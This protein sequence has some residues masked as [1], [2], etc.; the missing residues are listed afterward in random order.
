[1]EHL[2]ARTPAVS[3]ATAE[4]TAVT[5]HISTMQLLLDELGRLQDQVLA[6]LD[7][8]TQTRAVLSAFSRTR[9]HF[10]EIN[11]SFVPESSS[12]IVTRNMPPG[13]TGAPS[14]PLTWVTPPPSAPFS[15][16]CLRPSVGTKVYVFTTI[17][18]R[19]EALHTT[20]PAHPIFGPCEVGHVRAPF[21]L[22]GGRGAKTSWW[23]RCNSL[24]DSVAKKMGPSIVPG[25]CWML[26]RQD[27]SIQRKQ[28]DGRSETLAHY[29][30][31][32]LLAF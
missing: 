15:L 12:T 5:S 6:V 17:W 3:E 14:S 18:A 4:T 2:I 1:M 8:D 11:E 32:R 30:H 31:H 20:S 29:K 21:R 26:D 22:P 24:A 23:L 13:M 16:L 10:H 28:D 25:S 27:T 9:N 19:F 7:G